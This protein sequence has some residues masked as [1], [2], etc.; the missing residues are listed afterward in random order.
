MMFKHHNSYQN[1]YV[2]NN[3]FDSLIREQPIFS[4]N[5]MQ[6]HV[7]RNGF[8]FKCIIL[9]CV[10]EGFRCRKGT[11]ALAQY[12]CFCAAVFW[13]ETMR[14]VFIAFAKTSARMSDMRTLSVVIALRGLARNT[15]WSTK[16]CFFGAR[17][18]LVLDCCWSSYLAQLVLGPGS[19]RILSFS[20]FCASLFGAASLVR[21]LSL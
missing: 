20:F 16:G 4:L 14:A 1:S 9:D 5:Q 18:P 12:R 21:R 8:N 11:E 19:S 15:M 3:S 10:A 2:N 6:L 17:R 13:G 7:K